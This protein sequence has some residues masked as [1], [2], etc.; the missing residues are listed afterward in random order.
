MSVPIQSGGALNGQNATAD[1]MA[2]LTGQRNFDFVL[3][4]FD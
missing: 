1:K 4:S 2:M 3:E